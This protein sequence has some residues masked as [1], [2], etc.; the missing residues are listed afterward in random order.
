MVDMKS[1]RLERIVLRCLRSGSGVV[2]LVLLFGGEVARLED[3]DSYWEGGGV[4][5][6]KMITRCCM[7]KK[8]KEVLIL[9]DTYRFREDGQKR[10]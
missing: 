6:V 9:L 7:V 2:E 3:P 4:E 1:V 8:R 10:I 5:E